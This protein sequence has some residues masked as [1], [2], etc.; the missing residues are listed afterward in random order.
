MTMQRLEGDFRDKV[1]KELP[2]V[3]WTKLQTNQY[4][5]KSTPADYIILA[6]LNRFLCECKQNKNGRF[7]LARLTQKD[8]LIKF[9]KADMKNKAFVL[10]AFWL[11]NI[12]SSSY[13]LIPIH[14]MAPFMEQTDKKTLNE[15]QFHDVFKQYKKTF[16]EMKAV[17]I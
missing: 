4:A 8:D 9:E 1:L 15:S 10:V 12:K 7:E 6:P 14:V 5:M 3:W 13:Y 11:R 17:F 16:E 2:N